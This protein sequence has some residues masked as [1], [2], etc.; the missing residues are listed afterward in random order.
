MGPAAEDPMIFEVES[1]SSSDPTIT[2]PLP[3]FPSFTAMGPIGDLPELPSSEPPSRQ[4]TPKIVIDSP[5]EPG[6]LQFPERRGTRKDVDHLRLPSTISPIPS[7]YENLPL[8][9]PDP[10]ADNEYTGG[11]SLESGSEVPFVS[12]ESRE[13]NRFNGA[14]ASHTT[15]DP[16][17]EDPNVSSF[18]GGAVQA[19]PVAQVG[20]R[21]PMFPGGSRP[22]NFLGAM[23]TPTKRFFSQQS[24]TIEINESSQ[25]V[26]SPSANGAEK[27]RG[28]APSI[29]DDVRTEDDGDGQKGEK[30]EKTEK[31]GEGEEGW[32]LSWIAR[33]FK[34]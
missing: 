22:T 5:R 27:R 12:T 25:S 28:S 20:L 15:D 10:V 33:Q 9:S 29:E 4:G 16:E 1:R 30:S 17:D 32:A 6:P 14:N 13:F 19:I 8:L 7:S 34:S 31:T 23:E 24:D 2:A 26:H 18:G 11:V 3:P 21:S